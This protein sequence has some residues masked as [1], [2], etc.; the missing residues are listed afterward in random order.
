MFYVHTSY[1]LH[2]NIQYKC[3]I[4]LNSSYIYRTKVDKYRYYE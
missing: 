1:M 2:N 4:P 3:K